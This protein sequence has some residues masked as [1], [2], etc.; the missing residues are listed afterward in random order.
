L[1]VHFG[2]KADGVGSMNSRD[3]HRNGVKVALQR[4]RYLRVLDERRL[5]KRDLIDAVDDSRATVSR[6]LSDLSDE[7]YIESRDGQYQTTGAGHALLNELENAIA[8]A[9]RRDEL[10]A[11]LA[12]LGHDVS[13]QQID[14]TRATVVSHTVDGT[15]PHHVCED[16]LARIQRAEDLLLAIPRLTVPTT[17]DRLIDHIDSGN[18]LELVAPRRVYETIDTEYP[19][20]AT[21]LDTASVVTRIADS[22]E[23]GLA[24]ERSSGKTTLIV[25]DG[26]I[27]SLVMS[28]SPVTYEWAVDICQSHSEKELIQ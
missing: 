10:R 14:F 20:L 8:T 19:G 15:S 4:I 18:G 28:S 16:F 2:T 13:L 26:Y 12:P 17:P 5:C 1:W 23:F 24:V 9:A 25:Y 27:H 3:S 21:K 7:Q 11:A 6:A 22:L